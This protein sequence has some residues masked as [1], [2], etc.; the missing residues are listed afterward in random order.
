LPNP[1]AS[2]S[3][4]SISSARIAGLETLDVVATEAVLGSGFHE[5]FTPWLPGL[6]ETSM[7]PETAGVRP[8]L[9]TAAGRPLLRGSRIEIARKN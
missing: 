8:V 2:T 5:R 1:T 4:T 7:G 6:E 9:A 3:R